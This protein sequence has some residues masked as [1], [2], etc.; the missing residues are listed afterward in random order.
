[1]SEG[2]KLAWER[3]VG[4]LEDWAGEPN[5]WIARGLL[6]VARLAAGDPVLGDLFP[7]TVLNCLAFGPEEDAPPK[8]S[9]PSVGTDRAGAIFVSNRTYAWN[10]EPTSITEASS[11][12]T[13]L[14]L[15]REQLHFDL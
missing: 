14:A 1:M 8:A 12:E 10:N 7:F 15:V 5:G 11:P 4:S 2:S 6:P 3:F 13:A 9:W